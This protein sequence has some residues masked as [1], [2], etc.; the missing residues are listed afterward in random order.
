MIFFRPIFHRIDNKIAHHLALGCCFISTPRGIAIASVRPVTIEV[1]R[2]SKREIRS[3]I[4]GR[5]VVDHIHNNTYAC[6]VERLDHL[7]H[8]KDAS[9]RISRIR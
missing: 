5:M 4:F 8:L 6:I 1:P 3:I 7:L 2:C 9:R